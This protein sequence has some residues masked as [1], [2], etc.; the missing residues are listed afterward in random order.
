METTIY[1]TKDEIEEV[2]EELES[3]IVLA[4]INYIVSSSVKDYYMDILTQLKLELDAYYDEDVIYG[5]DLGELS[6]IITTIIS[7]MTDH[8]IA[9]AKQFKDEDNIEQTSQEVLWRMSSH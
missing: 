7:D 9:Y 5:H 1:I 3:L 8:Y 4:G 6:N 2:I